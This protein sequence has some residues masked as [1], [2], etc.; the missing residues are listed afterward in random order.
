MN[1][2]KVKHFLKINI[3]IEKEVVFAIKKINKE[4]KLPYN[5]N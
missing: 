4:L 3:N 1:N 5:F 2:S